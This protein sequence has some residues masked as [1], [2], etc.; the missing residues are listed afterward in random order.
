L[1]QNILFEKLM[2]ATAPGRITRSIWHMIS[3]VVVQWWCSGGA[4]VVQWWCSGGAV[5]VHQW[6]QRG[7]SGVN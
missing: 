5:V 7:G 2:T 4:V 3:A 1:V 6:Q